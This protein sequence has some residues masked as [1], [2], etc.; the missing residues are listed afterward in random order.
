MAILKWKIK[1][2]VKASVK[3]T[4]DIEVASSDPQFK[5]VKRISPSKR[6]YARGAIFISVTDSLVPIDVR[7]WI[8][9]K[10]AVTP[11]I[12][13]FRIDRDELSK[14]KQ[15]LEVSP[16]TLWGESFKRSTSTELRVCFVEKQ[17]KYSTGVDVRQFVDTA[18]Y[19]GPT[20]KGLR[21]GLE[22]WETIRRALLVRI[23]TLL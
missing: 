12:K 15:L 14:W 3:Q 11:T 19:T 1:P 22:D 16:T 5:I 10:D 20:S 9:G 13:G 17:G 4:G 23:V 7:Y 2:T 18:K 8:E 6:S 21:F